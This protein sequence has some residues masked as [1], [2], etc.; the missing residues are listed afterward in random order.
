MEGEYI[1]APKRGP[2]RQGTCCI[3]RYEGLYDRNEYL[4]QICNQCYM[5][6]KKIHPK[7]IKVNP[8]ILKFGNCRTCKS[9][10]LFEKFEYV[11]QTC[12]GC[13]KKND[14][15][16]DSLDNYYLYEEEFKKFM[17]SVISNCKEFSELILKRMTTHEIMPWEIAKAIDQLE[18]VDD[19][20]NRYH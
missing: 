1:D 19:E 14:H 18:E 4:S 5:E 10:G 11:T 8:R 17:D 7:R 15:N 6:G 16:M 20:L 3:C 12:R 13:L 9:E 2:L